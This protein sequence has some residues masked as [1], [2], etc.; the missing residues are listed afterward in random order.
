MTFARA[1]SA[2]VGVILLVLVAPPIVGTIF[3]SFWS[4]SPIRP[5]G[6]ATLA[7]WPDV[8]T[9]SSFIRSFLNTFLLA[10]IATPLASLIG[11]FLAFYVARTDGRARQLVQACIY[12]NL[13]VSP[14]ILATAWIALASPTAGLLNYLPVQ[15]LGRPLLDVYTIPGIAFVMVTVL[16]PWF[17]T[18]VLPAMQHVDT[19]LED[20]AS[21]CG[22]GIIDRLRTVTIPLLRAALTGSMILVVVIAV[23]MFSIPALLGAPVSITVLPYEVYRS[24]QV[25]PSAWERAAVIGVV[26]LAIAQLG[27]LLQQ[28][29]VG[30]V[31]RYRSAFGAWG[32]PSLVPLGR[33]DGALTALCVI[34]CFIATV[35][36]V[37]ALLLGAFSRYAAGFA[38]SA[39]VLTLDNFASTAAS[40]DFALA[41]RNSIVAMS[42]GAIA[43]TILCAAATIVI[44][45]L[46]P[47]LLG[48]AIHTAIRLPIAIPGIVLGAGLLWAY[49]RL[50]LPIYG[51]LAIVVIAA[52]TKFLPAT[53]SLLSGRYLQL[54]GELREAA[55]V[56]GAGA[57]QVV[58]DVD[59]P[60]MR[61]ALVAGL[62]LTMT[63]VAGEVNASVMV[64]S[65]ES[66]T[67]PVLLWRILE[68]GQAQQ[69]TYV[70]ALVQLALTG[71]LLMVSSRLG[72]GLARSQ[73][74]TERAAKEE[75]TA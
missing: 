40:P 28:R 61:G 72:P 60:L 38:L 31:R 39:G 43:A 27:V 17:F 66:I 33:F 19:R 55:L 41:L 2:V 63:L 65:R 13:M 62:L 73:R 57:G 64:F 1:F 26:L 45:S 15:L 3:G 59:L 24:V 18:T 46:Q 9:S 74:R 7:T 32:A 52:G 47:R 34:Y 68:T 51:T 12:V 30:D 70:V 22:A 5:G 23:E 71:A 25:A 8:L 16:T 20:A 50:P 37:I 58:R 36:P 49:F 53:F 11:G 44:H 69:N 21:I 4:Q 6:Y 75:G 56:S 35:L 42:V 54:P 48:A 29:F 10:A 14:F 67:L